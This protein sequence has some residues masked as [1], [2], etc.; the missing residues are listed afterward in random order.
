MKI[1][2][3]NNKKI[4]ISII[5][6]TLLLICAGAYTVYALNSQQDE[7]KKDAPQSIEEQINNVKPDPEPETK[8][9]ET[10][11]NTNTDQPNPVTTDPGTNLRS[12]QLS[13]TADISNN[14]LYVRGGIN[15]SV[16]FNG[17]CYATLT[18]PGGQSI[19]KNTTL[20]QNASTTDCMTIQVPVSE[21]SKGKW[22]I[23]LNYTS[24]DSTGTSN[25]YSI[26]I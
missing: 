7:D 2:R 15:N 9:E 3:Q 13:V 8:T 10:I 17:T 12:L 23:T 24:S 26:E 22:N 1:N 11:N 4:T 5:A 6:V 25:A 19:R 20:L 21:L 18:G 14:T 16:E